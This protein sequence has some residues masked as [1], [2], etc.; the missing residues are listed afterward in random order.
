MSSPN[1]TVGAK[2]AIDAPVNE[3][4]RVAGVGGKCNPTLTPHQRYPAVAQGISVGGKPP[5]RKVTLLHL[6]RQW[7]ISGERGTGRRKAQWPSAK[8][9]PRRTG[10]E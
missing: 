4:L 6:K 9:K 10:A 1:A 2:S 7:L 3:P 5:A 8:K